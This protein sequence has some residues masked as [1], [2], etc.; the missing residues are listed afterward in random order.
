MRQELNWIK[1]NVINK[2]QK[3]NFRWRLAVWQ[4]APNPNN[5]Q[6]EAADDKQIAKI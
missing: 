2:V 4:I 1:A 6:Q 5:N 3:M